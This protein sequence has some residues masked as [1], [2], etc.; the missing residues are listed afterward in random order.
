MESKLKYIQKTVLKNDILLCCLQSV[1]IPKL[2]PCALITE[3]KKKKKPKTISI[4]I[5]Y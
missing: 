3:Q 2:F 5:T 4:L 1:P